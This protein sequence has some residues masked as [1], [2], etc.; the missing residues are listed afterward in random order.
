M[1]KGI[2]VQA[3]AEFI[4]ALANMESTT[5]DDTGR[6]IQIAKGSDILGNP[7]NVVLWL[8][9][10][11]NAQGYRLRA[12]DALSLGAMGK[13]YA[14]EAGRTIKIRYTGLPGGDSEAV[15]TFR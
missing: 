2:P 5:T 6:V 13:F 4:E 3:S 14:V 1:G 7:L 15:V 10:F 11:A 12:G 8:T 9:K